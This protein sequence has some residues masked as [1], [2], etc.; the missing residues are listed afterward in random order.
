MSMFLKFSLSISFIIKKRNRILSNSL[1]QNEGKRQLSCNMKMQFTRISP[2]LDYNNCWGQGQRFVHCHFLRPGI[3]VFRKWA[4]IHV[5][6]MNTQRGIYGAKKVILKDA[7]VQ[8]SN[9]AIKDSV[10]LTLSTKD[11]E[12]E[13]NAL[14]AITQAGSNKTLILNPSNLSLERILQTG[15]QKWLSL[16]KNKSGIYFSNKRVLCGN[17]KYWH[18]V[19]HQIVKNIYNSNCGS[20]GSSILCD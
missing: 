14:M 17:P 1:T 10:Y 16:R 12:L 11:N 5:C 15:V 19:T 9:D 3:E 13:L 7:A 4:L 20:G 18:L 2:S 8:C 6:G